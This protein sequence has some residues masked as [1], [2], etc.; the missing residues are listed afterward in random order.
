MSRCASIITLLTLAAFAASSAAEPLGSLEGVVAGSVRLSPDGRR[1]AMVIEQPAAPPQGGG[2]QVVVDGEASGGLFDEIA[3][4]MPLFSN[5]G[6]R[7]AFAARRG[8]KTFVVDDGIEYEAGSITEDGWPVGNLVIAPFGQAVLWQIR[9]GGKTQLVVNGRVVDAFNEAVG[10]EQQKTWGVLGLVFDPTGQSFAFRGVR[11]GAMVP[12]VGLSR[13]AADHAATP[14]AIGPAFA[15]IGSGSPIPVPGRG[16]HAFAFITCSESNDAKTQAHEDVAA[17]DTSPAPPAVFGRFDEI[18]RDTLAWTPRDPANVW[19]TA[20]KGEGWTA[21]VRG[22]PGSFYADVGPVNALPDGRAF[23]LAQRDGRIVPVL[24]GLDAAARQELPGGE[25]VQH[26]ARFA[27]DRGER[28][29]YVVTAKRGSRVVSVRPGDPAVAAAPQAESSPEYGGVDPAR[30][31]LSADG[32]RLAFV[33]Q[34]KGREL[35]VIDGVEG[36][37]YDKVGRPVFSSDGGRVAYR[38]MAKGSATVIVDGRVSE[39]YDEVAIDT[40]RFVPHRGQ[41]VYAARTG[42]AWRVYVDGKPG[43]DCERLVSRIELP[44]DGTGRVFYAARFLDRDGV[45][46]AVVVDGRRAAEFD[47]IFTAATRRLGIDGTAT[48]LGRRGRNIVRETLDLP[49]VF[50]ASIPVAEGK[51]DRVRANLSLQNKPLCLDGRQGGGV[52]MLAPAEA[53]W[54]IAGLRDRFPGK[55]LRFHAVTGIDTGGIDA[56]TASGTVV[57]EVSVDGERLATSPP[58]LWGQT[59]VF[60]VV[61]PDQAARL[62]LAATSDSGQMITWMHAAIVPVTQEQRQ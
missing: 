28:I 55:M 49:G 47:E 2:R 53:A 21:V 29:A 15:S 44:D 35:A 13:P 26:A 39:H 27:S 59:H 3:T 50:L 20:R 9:G 61:V 12:V 5:D 25:G 17:L 37:V 45:T 22:K 60:D 43:P 33:A 34:R 57:L 56:K 58:L 4:G 1:I 38:A 36:A 11:D 48:F 30:V 42:P 41:V 31:V 8:D 40:P 52:G 51:A 62:E 16:P 23:F 14:L 19:F 54:D 6:S 7:V 18:G 46:E 10:L 32:G 24:V